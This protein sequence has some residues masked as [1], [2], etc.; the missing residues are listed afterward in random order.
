ME[1]SLDSLDL[2]LGCGLPGHRWIAGFHWVYA[3]NTKGEVF[4]WKLVHG[5]MRLVEVGK[6]FTGYHAFAILTDAYGNSKPYCVAAVELET[7]VG[8]RP[9]PHHFP[10]YKDG[11]IRNLTLSN[12]CWS[13]KYPM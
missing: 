3:I 11:D 9:S 2:D 1:E 4:Q 10:T 6:S 13:D 7:F 8:P 5:S 12:L